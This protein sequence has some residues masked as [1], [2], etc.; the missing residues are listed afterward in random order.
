MNGPETS[1]HA[2]DVPDTV[3]ATWDSRYKRLIVH[4]TRHDAV[5][6]VGRAPEEIEIVSYQREGQ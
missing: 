4:R 6:E 3:W 5:L 1:I 2:P